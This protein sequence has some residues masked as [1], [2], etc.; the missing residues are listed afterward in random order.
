MKAAIL[1]WLGLEPVEMPVEGDVWRCGFTGERVEVH[2]VHLDWVGAWHVQV[3]L[4]R[5]G[6]SYASMD[7]GIAYATSKGSRVAAWR[8]AVRDHALTLE[9]RASA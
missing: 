9:S 2:R 8:R 4:R 5:D 3:R 6:A 1:R 7:F